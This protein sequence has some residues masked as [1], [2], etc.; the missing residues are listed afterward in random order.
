MEAMLI[1]FAVFTVAV[2]AISGASYGIILLQDKY[3][4][5]QR[6]KTSSHARYRRYSFYNWAEDETSRY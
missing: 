2:L 3:F 1:F 6:V 4:T 5:N